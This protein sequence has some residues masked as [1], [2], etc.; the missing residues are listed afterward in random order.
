MER[1]LLGG[2]QF[3]KVITWF[4]VQ[5]GINWHEWNISKVNQAAQAHRVSAIVVFKKFTNADLSQITREISRDYL[6]IIYM[7]KNDYVFLFQ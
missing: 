4:P 7:W 5:F 6:L 2:V 1:Y 3:V